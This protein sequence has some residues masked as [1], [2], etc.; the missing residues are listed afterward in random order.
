ML[1]FAHQSK[2]QWDQT[3][4]H[5]DDDPRPRFRLDAGDGGVCVGRGRMRNAGFG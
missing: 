1:P 3:R 2:Y 4:H 5:H